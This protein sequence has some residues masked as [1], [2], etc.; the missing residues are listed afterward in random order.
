MHLC[1]KFMYLEYP[2]MKDG[3]KEGK[4]RL[5]VC[6]VSPPWYPNPQYDTT[7]RPRALA[8]MMLHSLAIRS[9]MARS[10]F[11][12]A[13]VS[14]SV[15]SSIIIWQWTCVTQYRSVGN[16]Y[17]LS[18]WFQITLPWKIIEDFDEKIIIFLPV[19]NLLFESQTV[20]YHWC[21]CRGSPS[22]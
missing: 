2:D 4:L 1:W 17:G 11:W 16:V 3:T 20:P 14:I 8:R 7:G 6:I 19:S 13:R 12:C 15:L 21:I 9:T 10:N 18:A 22:C 5:L